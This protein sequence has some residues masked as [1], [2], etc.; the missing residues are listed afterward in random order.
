MFYEYKRKLIDT[1]KRPKKYLSCI[2]RF[3]G[4]YCHF[5]P[6]NITFPSGAVKVESTTLYM[7][8]LS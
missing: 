4:K 7:D 2:V 3:G 8:T 6:A 5:L 1:F